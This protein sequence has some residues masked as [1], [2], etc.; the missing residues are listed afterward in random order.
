LNKITS[1]LIEL[2]QNRNF[3]KIRE[4]TNH[5]SEYIKIDEDKD[6]KCFSKLIMLY[7]P[8]K[9][10]VVRKKLDILYK[11]GN[12]KG[13][14]Q[15]KHILCLE[16]L[17]HVSVVYTIDADIDYKPEYRWDDFEENSFSVFDPNAEDSENYIYYEDAEKSFY[18]A[19]KIR[20]YGDLE[21]N[22]PSYYLEDFEDIEL[23]S[24]DIEVLDGVEFCKHVVVL[25]LSDNSISDINSLWNLQRIEELYLSDNQIEIIDAI[26]NLKNLRIVDLSSN[27]IDDISILLHLEHLEFVNMIGN[28]VSQTQINALKNRGVV[29]MNES[30]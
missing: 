15:F 21:V 19:V 16:H 30:I 11:E 27:K 3:D 6:A 9:A 2:Y 13:L 24:S 28:N 23:S 14:K 22:F 10:D 7:H 18:N 17:E 5:I 12:L 1:K 26:G 25:D 29:V 8:D 4:I 20:I